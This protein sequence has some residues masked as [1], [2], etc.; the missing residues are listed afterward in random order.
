[1]AIIIPWLTASVIVHG[2]VVHDIAEAVVV[3]VRTALGICV[4]VV[5]T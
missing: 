5:L 2:F 1:M 4:V 3:E